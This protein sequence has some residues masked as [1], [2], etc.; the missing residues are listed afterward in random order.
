MPTL[1]SLLTLSFLLFSFSSHADDNDTLTQ[2]NVTIDESTQIA[3]DLETIKLQGRHF[4]PS[5]ESFA[6]RVNLLPLIQTRASYFK[7]LAEQQTAD[8]QLEQAQ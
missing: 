7:I 6:T 1:P 3:S 4:N 8:L 2:H 5:I